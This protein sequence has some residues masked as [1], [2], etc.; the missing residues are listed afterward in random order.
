M[1]KI[2]IWVTVELILIFIQ[3]LALQLNLM[4]LTATYKNETVHLEDICLK[5]LSPENN[6]C[7]VFSALQYWQLSL[8]NL[9]LCRTSW[10]E[11]EDCKDAIYAEPA[12]DWH[13]QILGCT[14]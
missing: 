8:K 3:V 2:K 4:N 13:D 10:I 6:A 12:E 14:K 11:P 1:I 5:P 9:E 7:T